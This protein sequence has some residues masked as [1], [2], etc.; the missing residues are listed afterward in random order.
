MALLRKMKSLVKQIDTNTGLPTDFDKPY[1]LLLVDLTAERDKITNEYLYGEFQILRGRRT[2]FDYI[3]DSVVDTYDIANS[4]ILSGNISFGN[5]VS[6]YTFMRYCVEKYKYD[7]MDYIMEL[8][9]RMI[10]RDEKLTIEDL[11]KLYMEELSKE[12]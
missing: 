6:V 3:K 8:N 11:N 7:D 1:L 2:L 4:Y 5:E 12:A 9:Q 10:E